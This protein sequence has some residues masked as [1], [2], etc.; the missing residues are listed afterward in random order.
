MAERH[1]VPSLSESFLNE[2]IEDLVRR[3][4][5]AAPNDE[6]DVLEIVLVLIMREG[7][8]KCKSKA[9]SAGLEALQLSIVEGLSEHC[10]QLLVAPEIDSCTGNRKDDRSIVIAVMEL[11]S[12]EWCPHS[13]KAKINKRAVKRRRLELMLCNYKSPPVLPV[14]CETVRES[15]PFFNF[16]LALHSMP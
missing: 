1:E 10:Q 14:M 2:E 12:M 5:S 4:R 11:H 8:S 3:A 16:Q 7:K 13:T 6:E 9:I 15:L